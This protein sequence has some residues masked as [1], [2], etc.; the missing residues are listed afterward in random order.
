MASPSTVK[1]GS[2]RGKLMVHSKVFVSR[3][4]LDDGADYESVTTRS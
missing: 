3:I 4:L 1:A 2:G